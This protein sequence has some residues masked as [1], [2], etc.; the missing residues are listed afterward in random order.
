MAQTNFVPG[1]TITSEFLNDV[2]K[3]EHIS[4]TPAGTGAVATDVQARLRQLD[5]GQFFAVDSISD[6]LALPASN[7]NPSVRYFVKGYRAG[8]NYGGGEFYWD[9]TSTADNDLCI[10]FQ[11]PGVAVGRFLRRLD[12]LLQ[13]V[14]CGA[15]P[16]GVLDSSDAI[17]RAHLR[18]RA[19]GDSIG[20]TYL[21]NSTVRF[22]QS[23]FG[24]VGNTT[25]RTRF[26]KGAS[27]VLFVHYPIRK[28]YADY[29]CD[30]NGFATAFDVNIPGTG[31]FEGG[32]KYDLLYNI[33]VQNY[34]LRGFN[35]NGPVFGAT[36]INLR[37]TQNA[38]DGSQDNSTAFYC[39]I[40][41]AEGVG[42]VTTATNAAFTL[43]TPS[44]Y[45]ANN[46][47]NNTTFID[48]RYLRGFRISGAEV[49]CGRIGNFVQADG[50]IQGAFEYI[51]AH[52]PVFASCISIGG[53][54]NIQTFRE[55]ASAWLSD[56]NVPFSAD[57]G[58]H[59]FRVDG[60]SSLDIPNVTFHNQLG[61]QSGAAGVVG[62]VAVASALTGQVK[63]GQVIEFDLGGGGFAPHVQVA[64]NLHALALRTQ[65][66][67]SRNN[68]RSSAQLASAATG[69]VTFS[70]FGETRYYVSGKKGQIRAS[71]ASV[72]NGAT[73]RSLEILVS[74]FSN[75]DV[76]Q[77]SKL[78]GTIPAATNTGTRLFFLDANLV[79]LEGEYITVTVNVPT[80]QAQGSNSLI[81]LQLMLDE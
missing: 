14:D 80:G 32:I 16:T 74:V 49:A 70:A 27:N 34:T 6:L 43:I 79:I 73:T 35:F 11:I 10:V 38:P 56:S 37:S 57:P 20:G 36:G 21:C 78:L 48:A 30:A 55:G 9:A 24:S 1:T 65:G 76:L 41:D 50:D 52:S 28:V 3:S 47:A 31:I 15:D 19:V 5:A 61:R 58:R 25:N 22:F 81:T 12:G 18:L 71:I 7:R 60:A 59:I 68:Y 77:R 40:E 4:Y 72:F 62:L 44:T 23:M 8:T 46:R 51:N 2:Q 64:N 39:A 33:T 69:P 42:T 63:V 45:N 66:A 17:N 75:A 67:G 53:G 54:T 26:V 13:L 29:I